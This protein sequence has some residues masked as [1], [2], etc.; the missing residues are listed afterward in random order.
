MTRQWL[1]IRLVTPAAA[2]WL[3]GIST[4]RMRRLRLD[5]KLRTRTV[6]WGGKPFQAYEFESLRE[7]WGDP[8]PDRLDMTVK[9]EWGDLTVPRDVG[10]VKWVLHEVLPHVE[11]ED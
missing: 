10:G 2:A 7:R 4:A 11:W 8:D 9:V 5:G 1:T 6:R 3:W